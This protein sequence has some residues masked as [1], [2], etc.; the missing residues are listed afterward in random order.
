MMMAVAKAVKDSGYE[1]YYTW[2]FAPVTGEEYGLADTFADYLQG[3]WHR[4]SVSHTEWAN[5]AVVV[6][7]WELHSPPY[8][9]QV[10]LSPEMFATTQASLF[11]SQTGGMVGSAALYNVFSW[12]DGFVYEATGT[13]SL[14]FLA[15]GVDY[16]Q[17]YH[18]D[19][20][21]LDTLMFPQLEPTLRAEAKIALEIDKEVIPYTFDSRIAAIGASLGV[22]A[23]NRYGA[24]SA[25][26]T[27]AF[28]ALRAAATAA[29]GAPYSECAFDHTRA[30]VR[31]IEDEYTSLHVYEATVGP[32]HQVRQDLV[33]LERTI[34][35]LEQGNAK[36]ALEA[37]GFVG[38]NGFAA[39]E[40][41]ELFDL[42]LLYFD[43]N[44]EKISWY[45]AGQ[46]PPMLDLYDVWHSI[47][48]KDQA[49]IS[50]FSVEIAELSSHVPSEIAVFRERIDQLTG[51][52]NSAAAEL[53][54]VA[55]CG[56]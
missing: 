46:F 19:Y 11:D 39:I 31:I 1:P 12:T 34:A 16:S 38:M 22:G 5:D 3:A 25:G 14:T 7:N 23:M 43:P 27:A 37:L 18:T 53:E 6:L 45:G 40:S 35:W 32:H 24:D 52:L 44:Y 48:A 15:S 50:D 28:A 8:R 13:P 47:D 2:V 10:N 51:T 29:S 56:E 42:D 9:L 17:R 33:N 41:R 36:Y 20:D 55:V 30:A 4:V 54:A 21:S 26:A 49:G